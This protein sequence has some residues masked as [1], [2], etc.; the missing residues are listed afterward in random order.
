MGPRSAP[1]CLGWDR[2]SLRFTQPWA[3]RSVGYARAVSKRPTKAVTTAMKYIA[4]C[5]ALLIMSAGITGYTARL[6][7]LSLIPSP[8][9]NRAPGSPDPGTSGH[10]NVY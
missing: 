1:L 5:T 8:S 10:R 7:V 4:S 2:I 6:L 3:V 9:G